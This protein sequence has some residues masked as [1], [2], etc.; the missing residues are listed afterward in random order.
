MSSITEQPEPVT[1]AANRL[2]GL[3]AAM[4]AKNTAAAP[5][6]ARLVPAAADEVSALMAAQFAVQTQ[7]YQ[8]V[9]A[10]THRAMSVQAA[11]LEVFA[12]T[13]TASSDSDAAT[14][15]A[16]AAAADL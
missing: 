13:L 5:P 9:S 12:S 6:T 16:D 4:N 7:I 2:A 8:A 1:A 11:A 3:G 14:E 15:G 10:Q